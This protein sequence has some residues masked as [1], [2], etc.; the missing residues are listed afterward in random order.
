VWTLSLLAL[1]NKREELGRKLSIDEDL[2]PSQAARR[3]ADPPPAQ[4]NTSAQAGR[5]ARG[6]ETISTTSSIVMPDTRSSKRFSMGYRKPRTVGC[7]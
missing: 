6:Q 7:P 4:P 3:A 1:I 5:R 2:T